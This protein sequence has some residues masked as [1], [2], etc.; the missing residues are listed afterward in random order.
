MH[1]F[2]EESIQFAVTNNYVKK[3]ADVICTEDK[4]GYLTMLPCNQMGRWAKLEGEIR[5]AG[6]NPYKVW[7]PHNLHGVLVG[8]GAS[9]QMEEVHCPKRSLK[10]S[11]QRGNKTQLSRYKINSQFFVRAKDCVEEMDK[12][13]FALGKVQQLSPTIAAKVNFKGLK[14]Q[15]VKDYYFG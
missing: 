5:S 1:K 13:K 10:I 6:R 14:Y 9:I 2:S 12:I 15:A 11:G 3:F 8:L 7:T 4:D